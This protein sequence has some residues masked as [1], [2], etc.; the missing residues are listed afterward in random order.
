LN[1]GLH[2]CKMGTLLLE[3]YLQSIFSSYLVIV[4]QEIFAQAGLNQDPPDVSF[5]SIR[6][7]RCEPL[8]PSWNVTYMLFK[9][10]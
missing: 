8:V 1:S 7:T 3:P 10:L 4:S 9:V 6:I 2:A 5:L